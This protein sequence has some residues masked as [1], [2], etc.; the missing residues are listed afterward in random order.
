MKLRSLSGQ[1]PH[2]E[3]HRDDV[4]ALVGKRQVLSVGDREEH[5]CLGPALGGLLLGDGEHLGNEVGGDDLGG[6]PLLG[7]REGDVAGAGA[8][9]EHARVGAESARAHELLAPAAVDAHRSHGVEDV[10]AVGDGREDALHALGRGT[11]GRRLRCQSCGGSGL[12]GFDDLTSCA[13]GWSDVAGDISPR[14]PAMMFATFSRT[15]S[16]AHAAT[17]LMVVERGQFSSF[18]SATVDW[19]RRS[20]SAFSPLI[21]GLA[22]SLGSGHDGVD[23]RHRRTRPR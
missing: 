3:S 21:A 1:V 11:A 19:E 13:A 8:Q 15:N 17:C 6:V 22:S 16:P 4:E 20:N 23:A 7:E 18:L 12:R 2:A 14:P 5:R 10:V 9:V